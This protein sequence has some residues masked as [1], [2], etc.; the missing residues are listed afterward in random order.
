MIGETAEIG[1]NV[2]LYQ[3][4]TL[5][6]TGFERGKRHPTV[7]DN[8]VVGI[9]R[10]AA[11]ADQ[12]R[13]LLEGRRELRGHPRRARRTRPWSATPAIPCGRAAASPTGPDADWAHLPDPV[14]DA[15]RSLSS[16]IRELEA[17]LAEVTGREP[18]PAAEVR[19]L[20]G[21]GQDPAGG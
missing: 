8:V 19:P 1:D 14:A 21:A 20:R 4:V 16:R 3:G 6:G 7:E 9:R 11:R 13:P 17:E 2:T 5:G 18:Q 10:E 12:R 15:I